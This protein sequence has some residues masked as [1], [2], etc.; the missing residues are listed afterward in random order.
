MP[1]SKA[2]IVLVI[3]ALMLLIEPL[4]D[5]WMG[6][7]ILTEH[8]IRSDAWPGHAKYHVIRHGFASIFTGL[9]CA[10]GLVALRERGARLRWVLAG[11][12]FLTNASGILS[13][14]L[15]P[16]MFGVPDPI[17]APGLGGP[18]MVGSMMLTGIGLW[19]AHREQR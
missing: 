15:S 18:A 10:W 4:A 7:G 16:V 19:M 14:L 6:L 8:H 2:Q 17:T 1:R 11:I 9:L 12:P 3:A 5:G 13:L